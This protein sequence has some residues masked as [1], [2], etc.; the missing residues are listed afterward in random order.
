MLTMLILKLI[1]HMSVIVHIKI[2]PQNIEN[3]FILFYIHTY[4]A[5]EG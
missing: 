4:Y 2:H 5:N 1:L 3:H